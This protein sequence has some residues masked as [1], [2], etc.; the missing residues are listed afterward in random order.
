M[1]FRDK[2]YENREII[3]GYT[4]F[5]GSLFTIFYAI[6]AIYKGEWAISFKATVL[7]LSFAIV[8]L[9]LSVYGIIKK[10]EEVSKNYFQSE[11]VIINLENN[12]SILEKE[13]R[14]SSETQG[15]IANISHNI[16]HEYRKLISNIYSDLVSKRYE[17]YDLRARSFEKFIL[18]LVNNIKEL[19]DIITRGKCNVCLKLIIPDHENPTSA[20]VKTFMRDSISYRERSAIDMQIPKFRYHENTAFKRIMEDEYPDSFYLSNDLLNER[21][22]KEYINLNPNWYKLYNAC[23][24]VPIRIFKEKID[25]TKSKYYMIGFICVDNFHGG[26]DDSVAFNILASYADSIF[27]LFVTFNDLTRLSKLQ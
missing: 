4:G 8:F 12:I 21:E 25:E 16:F 3:F 26:F 27:H 2:F 15:D 1:K 6:F 24:V 5:I 7:V 22:K 19:F 14:I 10:Y 17:L 13:T 23:L 20:F 9:S 11:Q 18:Y